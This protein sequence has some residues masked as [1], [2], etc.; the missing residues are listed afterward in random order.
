MG[1]GELLEVSNC[2]A[3]RDLLPDMDGAPGTADG[4]VFAEKSVL[5]FISDADAA[6]KIS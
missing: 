5:F 3:D 2:G 1:P 4:N 6:A